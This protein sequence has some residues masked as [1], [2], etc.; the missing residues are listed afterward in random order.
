MKKIILLSVLIV[1]FFAAKAQ[2]PLFVKGDKVANIGIGLGTGLGSYYKMSI[3][4]ISL[5]GEYGILDGL[6]EKGSIGVGAFLGFS[7]Y[8]YD[9]GYTYTSKTTH[10]YVG[11][12]GAFHYPFLDKLDTYAG[13]SFGLRY[14]SWKYDS[15]ISDYGNYYNDNSADLYSYWFV[16]ARYYFTEK[17]AGMAELGYGITY[18]NIGIS[19]K[20]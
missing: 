10:I 17:L 18:L 8:K 14:Y 7:S 6:L 1:A 12:R 4:P 13:L 19:F 2:D 20:L 15:A 16:G 9:W 3:P 11:P 5:S